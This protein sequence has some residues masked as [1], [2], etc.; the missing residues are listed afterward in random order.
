M[1][2][3]YTV[4]LVAL[5][6]LIGAVLLMGRSIRRGRDLA[7]S[8]AARHPDTYEAL[9]RPRPGYFQSVRR[10][11]FAQFVARREFENLSDPPLAAEF[12]DYRTDEARLLLSLLATLLLVGVL[13]LVVR[14]RS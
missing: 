5:G 1:A 6:W 14:Y 2:S 11:R 9:G 7:E 8:L 10:D 13:V 12:E 4:G 3:E